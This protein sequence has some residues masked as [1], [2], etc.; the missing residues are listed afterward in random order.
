[1][2]AV[3]RRRGGSRIPVARV[4]GLVVGCLQPADDE[5]FND[6]T[7][8]SSAGVVS[9]PA[10]MPMTPCHIVK[11]PAN[12]SVRQIRAVGSACCMLVLV[13][14]CT[15][16]QN[17]STP[18]QDRAEGSLHLHSC[19]H[20]DGTRTYSATC[21]TVLVRENRLVPG[22]RLIRL[23]VTILHSPRGS[24]RPPVFVLGGGPGVSNMQ[25][26]PPTSLLERHD[27]VM[28][29]YRGVDGS[30]RL[31]CPEVT[32][33]MRSAVDIAQHAASQQLGGAVQRCLSRH[34]H[35]GVDLDGYNVVEVLQDVEVVRAALGMPAIHLL[36]QSYGT[37]VAL[38]YAQEHPTRVHRSVM[39]GA[40]PPGHFIWWPKRVDQVISHYARLCLQ[41]STCR[42]RTA[43]LAQSFKR[44]AHTT[45]RQWSVFDINRGKALAG[46]FLLM[47]HRSS[48]PLAMDVI[49]RADQGDASG[50]A[51]M[52]AAFDALVPSRFVWGDLFVKG[53]TADLDPRL[54]LAQA[55]SSQHSFMGSPLAYYL[56]SAAQPMGLKR[57]GERYQAVHDSGVD[58]LIISGRLDLSTPAEQ[59]TEELL[60]HLMRGHQVILEDQGHVGDLWPGPEGCVL[61]LVVRYLDSGVVAQC[62][63]GK[64]PLR[65]RLF[66]PFPAP[67]SYVGHAGARAVLDVMAHLP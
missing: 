9:Q 20:R 39:I 29:G 30:V 5:D 46:V 4:A 23:P 62:N 63:V 40:N 8:R 22:C 25:F 17:G 24:P 49:L 59:A 60:P 66:P 28:V 6:L 36:S 48:A 26:R 10:S 35:Q 52:S 61:D 50:L 33:A 67:V 21:G 57:I 64:Q 38:L 31:D 41:D 1:M 65:W 32:G 58:T 56:W 14:A 18:G 43:D 55:L 27:V 11:S 15:M 12:L 44:V 47:F 16:A 53:L 2:A 3:R 51:V 19:I 37:R 45:P 13:A 34:R 54:N 7:T 42:S